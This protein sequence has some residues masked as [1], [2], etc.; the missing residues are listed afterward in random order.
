MNTRDKMIGAQQE[1]NQEDIAFQLKWQ[2]YTDTP[3]SDPSLY[4]IWK[5][6]LKTAP[7]ILNAG[8]Y[9]EIPTKLWD[10]DFQIPPIESAAHD[11]SFFSHDMDT[12]QEIEYE[13]KRREDAASKPR[14]HS[15][16]DL[17]SEL[18]MWNPRNLTIFFVE[19]LI[20]SEINIQNMLE[21]GHVGTQK[22]LDERIL[23]IIF[24]FEH[25]LKTLIA[26]DYYLSEPDLYDPIFNTHPKLYDLESETTIFA[27]KV[28]RLSL[29]LTS[30]HFELLKM[31][32]SVNFHGLVLP[33]IAEFIRIGNM[34]NAQ[35]EAEIKA[36]Q[37]EPAKPEEESASENKEP[38]SLRRSQRVLSG[39][40][41]HGK[42]DDACAVEIPSTSIAALAVNSSKTE[43]APIQTAPI[44]QHV[45]MRNM[46]DVK[47]ILKATGI[48]LA[49]A[50]V[51]A[52]VVVATIFSGGT[53]ALALAVGTATTLAS[54]AAV[55]GLMTA[56]QRAEHKRIERKHAQSERN[57]AHLERKRSI[58]ADLHLQLGQQDLAG[59]KEQTS[60]VTPVTT[61][62]L[63]TSPPPSASPVVQ[64]P[65]MTTASTP[66][67]NR[68]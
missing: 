61:Q 33:E 21:K 28:N 9:Q 38:G 10:D 49:I 7:A 20:D 19:Y 18:S 37:E 67:A 58:N 65:E 64:N 16:E 43:A 11:Q 4:T 22:K 39:L 32:T 25:I 31:R 59:K 48:I 5:K 13:N 15:I 12:R 8:N 40:C 50:A 63:T 47:Q 3:V 62:L 55:G 53:V 66:N 57:R 14:T 68:R 6:F 42:P 41:D 23:K 35:C 30:K 52:L 51:V 29:L 17:R 27:E 34:N 46:P 56:A 26:A 60:E 45:E 2:A 54:L 1:Q 24:T 44:N 36:L